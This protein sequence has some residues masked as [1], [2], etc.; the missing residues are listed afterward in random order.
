MNQ[1]TSF[2]HNNEKIRVQFKSNSNNDRLYS[3]WEINALTSK[4]N[5]FYYKTEMLNSIESLIL[6]GVNPKK[7][8][9]IN[10]SVDI[11]NQYSRYPNGIINI[12]NESTKL[13]YLGTPISLENNNKVHKLSIF[14]SAFRDIFYIIGKNNLNYINKH[15]TLTEIY[16]KIMLENEN[17]DI[18]AYFLD[19]IHESN[20]I[21]DE[22]I[23]KS[24]YSILKDYKTQLSSE[25][26]PD[27]FKTFQSL[28]RPLIVVQHEDHIELLGYELFKRSE[29][30]KDNPRFLE[31]NTISQNSPL[32]IELT[33][34]IA[35]LSG[36]ISVGYQRINLY[37]TDIEN[38]KEQEQKEQEILE[39]E[40]EI[41]ILENEINSLKQEEIPY[42]QDVE[43][44]E[45]IK[46]STIIDII[47]AKN[48]EAKKIANEFDDKDITTKIN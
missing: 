46:Q 3:N 33:M 17:L 43:D 18:E 38:L 6:S 14:F 21:L 31:T 22:K 11:H 8:W 28:E 15:S 30:R 45:N 35:F 24:I 47:N 41:N 20:S 32:I 26:Q 34:T 4:I 29:F 16:I 2:V 13:Y 1:Y 10:N 27:F 5:S 48:A 23:E 40:N 37:K 9:I 19:K 25:K 44:E 7:I 42:T 12:P 36:L 39:L